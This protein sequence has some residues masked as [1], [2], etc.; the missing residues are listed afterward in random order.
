MLYWQAAYP[1][2]E[3][4]LGSPSEGFWVDEIVPDGIEA[5]PCS[6]MLHAPDRQRG[7]YPLQAHNSASKKQWMSVLT[8]VIES[9][10]ATPQVM[11]CLP[12]SYDEDADTLSRA[13]NCS[14]TT[15]VSFLSDGRKSSSASDASNN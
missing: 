14:S 15:E 12:T 8:D 5:I 3:L 6:F 1:L 4:V 13:S 10:R 11:T 2:G 9:T 7:G